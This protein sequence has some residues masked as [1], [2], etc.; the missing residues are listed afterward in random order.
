MK[1]D[2]RFIVAQVGKTVGLDGHLKLHLKTDFPQ[3]FKKGAIFESNR[4]SL[5]IVSFNKN[6][7]LVK[8]KG[9]DTP[10]DAKSLTNALLF[11]DEEKTRRECPLD[12]NQ[13]YWFDIIGKIVKEGDKTLGLVKEIQR[14]HDI[15]Y[16][17]IKTDEKLVNEGLPKSFLI[18]Y[19]PRYI[20]S[21]ESD[22]I[23]TKDTMDILEAS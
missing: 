4:G 1:K 23:L 18:P 19:I 21:V 8:F 20:L 22:A 15:D 11:S 13:H 12:E 17:L 5:E 7:S 9:F 16:L 6:R 2:N 14:M 3:Q 10:E